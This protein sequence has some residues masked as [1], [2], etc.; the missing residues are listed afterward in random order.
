[1]TRPLTEHK[2]EIIARILEISYKHKLSHIGS[3]LT[4]VD[5]LID[6]FTHM[7]IGT[8]KFVLSSGH[9]GVAY[10]VILEKLGYGDAE[11]MLDYCG[12]HPDRSLNTRLAF[13]EGQGKRDPI[14]CST[15]SLG[16]GLPIA[17]GY[18]LADRDR[19][20]YC[21]IS[22]GECAEGSIWEAL[23]IK[24]ELQITNLK[25]YVNI[26]GYGAYSKIDGHLL[27]MRLRMFDDHIQPYYTDN[28]MFP[29]LSGW[30]AHYYVMNDED[31][32]LACRQLG[33]NA[34]VIG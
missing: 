14:H 17:L 29:F 23:R 25:V 18:A 16:Q 28:Q 12:I 13:I 33:A 32:Q 19:N 26:N 5:P 1:M 27:E 24:D 30:D 3:C 31:Y 4:S 8:D 21:L 20:T 2:K 6:I 34:E 11:I 22:D 15:G 7:D 10:Y 9:A